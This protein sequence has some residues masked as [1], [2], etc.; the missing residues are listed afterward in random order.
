M[1]K[2]LASIVLALALTSC[3]P[4]GSADIGAE[5]RAIE[6][7][8]ESWDGY[9]NAGDVETLVNVYYTDDAILAAT[10]EPD[11]RGHAAILENYRALRADPNLVLNYTPETLRVAASGDMAV[12][13]GTFDNTYTN[14]AT[15]MA[16]RDAGRY[17]VIYRKT[18]NA[19]RAAI[20]IETSQSP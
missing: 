8:E 6:A 4:A 17:V 10:S 7:L 11:H 15:H 1:K 3:A 16:A 13:T 19:W 14:P 9:W 18:N 2:I 20:D 5:T 12:R